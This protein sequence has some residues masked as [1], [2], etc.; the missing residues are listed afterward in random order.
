MAICSNC[1]SS[2]PNGSAFCTSCGARVASPVGG[3]AYMGGRPA[4]SWNGGVLE[5]VCAS[6]VASLM[7]TLTCGI[8][9]PWAACYLYNYILSHTVVDGRKLRFDGTGGS[10]FGNWIVW[11]ILTL[12]TCG[13]YGFWV[14]PKMY[15]WF[16]SNTHFE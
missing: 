7:I 15:N 11:F 12:I 2:V 14:T 1:G 6:I 10:L 4:S 8:A 16:A 13:I 5:T 9:T 3:G